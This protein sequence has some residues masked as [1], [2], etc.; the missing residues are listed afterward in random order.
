MYELQVLFRLGFAGP[1]PRG[2]IGLYYAS[3]AASIN[4]LVGQSGPE[5]VNRALTGS[6]DGPREQ[7]HAT[8][9]A[10]R[11]RIMNCVGRD[12]EHPPLRQARG[13]RVV[14]HQLR[15]LRSSPKPALAVAPKPTGGLTRLTITREVVPGL[16]EVEVAVPRLRPAVW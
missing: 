2:G 8:T 13:M 5:Q 16:V 10:H 9:A 4:L 12:R 15:H 7:M 11:C 1:R 14:A 6:R 3:L